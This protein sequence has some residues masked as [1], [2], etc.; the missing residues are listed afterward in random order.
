MKN[1]IEELKKTIVRIKKYIELIPIVEDEQ[2]SMFLH[3]IFIEVDGIEQVLEEVIKW[4]TL[5]I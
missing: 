5:I 3:N 2:K 1:T 4:I